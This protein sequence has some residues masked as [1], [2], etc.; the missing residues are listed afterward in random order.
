M[1]FRLAVLCEK[2]KFEPNGR[3]SLIGIFRQIRCVAFPYTHPKMALGCSILVA[4]SD[5]YAQV[6]IWIDLVDPDG[7]HVA[8]VLTYA[9][10]LVGGMDDPTMFD[11][12]V[13]L[14]NLKFEQP[15]DYQFSI[16][17]LGVLVKTVDLNLCLAN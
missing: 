3:M 9:A 14:V 13:D 17:V 5:R 8:R 10:M 6:D 16:F 1:D 7:K 12:D 4:D 2:V 15:G 11:F